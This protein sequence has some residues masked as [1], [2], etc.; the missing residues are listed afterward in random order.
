MDRIAACQGGGLVLDGDLSMQLVVSPALQALVREAGIPV[1][2]H[3]DR[4]FSDELQAEWRRL[5][6]PVRKPPTLVIGWTC[7][8]MG[9]AAIFLT[10]CPSMPF[11]VSI[12]GHRWFHGIPGALDPV[13]PES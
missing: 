10:S 3:Y 4:P 11:N 12:A 8:F 7:P 2:L 6:V 1:E 13:P 5:D 9:I